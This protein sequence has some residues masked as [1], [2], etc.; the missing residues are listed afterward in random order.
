MRFFPLHA[1]WRI[2][3]C[4]Q[5]DKWFVRRGAECKMHCP[6][7]WNFELDGVCG[8]KGALKSADMTR[9]RHIQF[10]FDFCWFIC[11]F[12][13]HTYISVSLCCL[14]FKLKPLK[15]TNSTNWWRV[16]IDGDGVG[17]EVR[18]NVTKMSM[19]LTDYTMWCRCCRCPRNC[20]VYNKK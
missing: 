2:N 20:D 5:P 9:H 11:L 7:R 10:S 3:F 18:K 4:L 16:T 15:T 1:F 13:I 6:S 8:D 12:F 19:R 17:V 14:S